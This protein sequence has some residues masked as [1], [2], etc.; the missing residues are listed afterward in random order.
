MADCMTRMPKAACSAAAS[1][2]ATASACVFFRILM[3]AAL[4]A[5]S[6]FVILNTLGSNAGIAVSVVMLVGIV[7]RMGCFHRF[8]TA[9]RA[10]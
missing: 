2:A 3:D 10:S 7:F 5:G 4:C 6:I 8:A 1:F 9:R